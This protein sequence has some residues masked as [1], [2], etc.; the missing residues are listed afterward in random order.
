MSAFDSEILNCVCVYIAVAN[1]EPGGRAN[2]RSH[3]ACA[4]FYR[5]AFRK[6][7]TLLHKY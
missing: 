6:M 7:C 4:A 2:E 1:E 3:S 5:L